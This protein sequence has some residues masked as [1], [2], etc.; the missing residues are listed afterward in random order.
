MAA[1]TDRKVIVIDDIASLREVLSGCLRKIGFKDITSAVDGKDAWEKLK[2]NADEGKPFELIFSDINMPHCHG[3]DLVKMIRESDVYKET[4]IIMVS[5]E[6]EVGIIMDAIE[7]GADNY[8]LKPFT[9]DTVK[10]KIVETA[11]KK[12]LSA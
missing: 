10:G 11:K 8:I 1:F 2:A 12:G 3:I 7:A 9:P 6:N 4:P 5:T